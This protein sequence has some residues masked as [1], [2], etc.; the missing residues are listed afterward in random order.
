MLSSSYNDNWDSYKDAVYQFFLDSIVGKLTFL[1][2]PVSC[3][4]F[5]PIGD[6][7]RSFWH[8]I[9]ENPENS[10]NDE[11]RLVDY[12]RCERI[13]WIPHIINNCNDSNVACW[14]NKRGGNTNTVLWLQQEKYMVIL[15]KRN[16]YYLLTTAYQHSDG[17]YKSNAREMKENKDPRNS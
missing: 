17:K 15:S 14:E 11:D 8:L 6:M 7:H 1:G 9:T 4:Y 16:G 12:Q 13:K 10:Q 2:L 3:R 5:Q